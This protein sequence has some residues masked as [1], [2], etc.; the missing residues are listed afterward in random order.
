VR[1]ALDGLYLAGAI[2]AAGFLLGILLLMMA[3]VVGRELGMQIRGADDLTA[4]FCAA[5]SFL[6][7]AYTFRRGEL[8]RVT[9][10]IEGRSA[11][12]RRF[13]ELFCLACAAAFLGFAVYAV[14]GF[15][16]ESWKFKELAQGMLP[17]PIWIPQLSF[18]AGITLLFIAVVDELITV[19]CGRL[20]AYEIAERERRDRG[21]IGEGV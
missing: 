17:I 1:R 5:A 19:A 6:P 12:T 15:V 18:V 21:E 8:I 2:A 4:W 3:Q 7:L 16:Y 10:W 9:L 14:V 20:P 13:A 11:R